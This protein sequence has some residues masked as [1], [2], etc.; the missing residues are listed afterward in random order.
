MDTAVEGSIN[1]EPFRA[2]GRRLLDRGFYAVYYHP[3]KEKIMI[4]SFHSDTKYLV[5][6]VGIIEKKTE[7]P[8]R[9]S[10]SSLLSEM[11]KEGIGT[12]STRPTM[13]QT[14]KARGYVRINRNTVYP[15]EKGMKLISC[16]EK[17]WG[18]YISPQ[19]TSRVEEEMEK[20]SRGERDWEELVRLGEEDFCGRNCGVS[21]DQM[22][23]SRNHN[24][25]AARLL[26]IFSH[27]SE[28]DWDD[29]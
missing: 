3:A 23:V 8:P 27:C 21:A 20:I 2:D 16:I 6:E 22:I 19:F 13:I 11:E 26:S 1:S 17:P 14:L 15:T 4:D 28:S 18:S 12:K 10:N 25:T 5:E 29:A 24:R 7:P 9:H